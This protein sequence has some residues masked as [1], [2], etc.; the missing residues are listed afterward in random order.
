MKNVINGGIKMKN[1][2]SV[3]FA[4]AFLI[5]SLG[6]SAQEDQFNNEFPENGYANTYEDGTEAVLMILEKES[7]FPVCRLSDQVRVNSDFIPENRIGNSE[8]TSIQDVRICQ[9]E[10][11]WVAVEEEM[12]VGTAIGNPTNVSWAILGKVGLVSA[13]IGCF[14]GIVTEALNGEK[15]YKNMATAMSL[16]LGSLGSSLVL[17]Y[18]VLGTFNTISGIT[19]IMILSNLIGKG[20]CSHLDVVDY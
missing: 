16:G 13:G 18:N 15:F 19:G 17:P 5:L 12:I 4:I 11:V 14:F 8:T 20:L 9:E 2:M 1:V 10:D 3:C 7:N 6:I